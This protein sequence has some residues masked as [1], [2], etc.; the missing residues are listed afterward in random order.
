MLRDRAMLLVRLKLHGRSAD[1]S[2]INRAF[3]DRRD[4]HAGL[5]GNSTEFVVQKVRYDFNKTWNAAGSRFSQWKSLG[6]Y[7]S[8][9]EGFRPEFG[10]CC[11]RSAVE[12][13]LRR[14]YDLP[15]QPWVDQERPLERVF[16][17]FVTTTA[18]S[19][20][21][22]KYS[23]L[24]ADTVAGRIKALMVKAGI[25]VT[26]FQPH[27]L[28]SASMQAAISAGEDVDAV[29]QRASVSLKVFKVYYD[30]PVGG[31]SS[32]GVESLDG[33]AAANLL[34]GLQKA[35]PASSEVSGPLLLEDA[36]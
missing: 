24:K 6:P 12:T 10:L 30:L 16:R 5:A 18:P 28:R 9:I 31:S 14:T 3:A 36:E 17:L 1:I 15:L 19:N 23:G 2:V 11:V 20:R 33:S 21:D 32:G 25:D 7:L 22:Y 34:V 26:A 13:Y 29:L 4:P 35:A 27:I 8:E